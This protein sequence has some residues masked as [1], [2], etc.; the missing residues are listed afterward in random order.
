L[1]GIEPLP[2]FGIWFDSVENHE[3]MSLQIL[4]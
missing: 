4:S 3:A 1:E 2:N